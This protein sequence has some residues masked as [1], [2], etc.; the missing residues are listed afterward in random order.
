MRWVYAEGL[1]WTGRGD[2]SVFSPLT[3]NFALGVQYMFQMS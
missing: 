3:S 2:V 1:R